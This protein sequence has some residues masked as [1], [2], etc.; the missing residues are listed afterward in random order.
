[1]GPTAYFTEVVNP[2][3]AKPPLELND[4]LA[5]LMLTFLMKLVFNRV[6]R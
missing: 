3:L 4:G 1:M 2:A 6:L 5:K